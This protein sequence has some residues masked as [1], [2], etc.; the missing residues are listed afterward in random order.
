MFDRAAFYPVYQTV[1][2]DLTEAVDL[3]APAEDLAHGYA[4]A[5]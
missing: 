4:D 2:H 5:H 3:W 1:D